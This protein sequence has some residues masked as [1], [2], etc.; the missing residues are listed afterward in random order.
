[1][2]GEW[3]SPAVK[4]AAAQN[5]GLSFP[6]F[7]QSFEDGGRAASSPNFKVAAPTGSAPARAV[8]V[9][10]NGATHSSCCATG[11]LDPCPRRRGRRVV[12][13]LASGSSSPAPARPTR[14]TSYGLNR[15]IDAYDEAGQENFDKALRFDLNAT[16]ELAHIPLTAL[17]RVARWAGF[18]ARRLVALVLNDAFTILTVH[19]HAHDNLAVRMS[20]TPKIVN[21]V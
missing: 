2:A 15:C 14:L 12:R 4:A 21:L 18:Y 8:L 6:R 17:A 1:M 7:R 11:G 3:I 19:V 20:V 5:F 16:H 13:V 9:S 10:L